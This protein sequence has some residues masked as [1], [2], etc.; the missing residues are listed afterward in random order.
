[1]ICEKFKNFKKLK[2]QI[3]KIKSILNEYIVDG[4]KKTLKRL[5]FYNEWLAE[6]TETKK[7]IERFIERFIKEEYIYKATEIIK[8]GV[9]IGYSSLGFPATL[10]NRDIQFDEFGRVTILY[11]G[12]ITISEGRTK[13]LPAIIRK[14]Q[15]DLKVQTTRHEF[16]R[17]H[18]F[19]RF[20]GHEH[21]KTQSFK[22]LEEVGGLLDISDTGID[23]TK[24]F[25][26]AFPKLKKVGKIFDSKIKKEISILISDYDQKWLKENLEEMK[27]NKEIEFEGEIVLLN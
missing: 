4:D 23:S 24:E 17:R 20:S 21:E 7:E 14:L 13:Y 25:K 3:E 5:E 11:N 8:K 16:R 18:D 15:G 6:I 27:K 12:G 9:I 2:K 19:E 10:N 22:G 26:R 1:M